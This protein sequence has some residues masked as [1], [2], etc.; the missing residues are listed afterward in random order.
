[1][2]LESLKRLNSVLMTAN[3]II[4]LL[5]CMNVSSLLADESTQSEESFSFETERT[6]HEVGE[7]IFLCVPEEKILVFG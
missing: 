5:F 1:M 3:F 2:L 4:I 7:T 6:S